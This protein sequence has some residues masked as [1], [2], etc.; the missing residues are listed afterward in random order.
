MNNVKQA[1]NEILQNLPDTP[2]G[3]LLGTVYNQLNDFQ[4]VVLKECCQKESGGLSLPLGS[5][6]TLISL[7]LSLYLTME[8]QELILVVA[9]KS[10]I[11]SWITEIRKFFDED[12]KY[13]VIHPSV[14]KTGVETWK[15]KGCTQLIITTPDILSK[16]YKEN[17]INRQFIEQDYTQQY[18][19]IYINNYQIP[20][21]PYLAHNIGSGLF[22]SIK[23]GCVVID[24][25]QTY[26]N[27][28]TLRCQALGSLCAKY[29]WLLSGT[30]FDEPTVERLLGYHI[31]LNAPGKPRNLPDTKQL[32]YSKATGQQ[33]TFKGLKEHL[34]IRTKNPVFTPPKVYEEIIEH[35][36]L[37]EE[38]KIYTM[39][40]QIL[41]AVKKEARR[42][43]LTNNTDDLKR[44]S[45]YKLVMIMYLRQ[46]LICPLIPIASIAIDASD[47]EK[48]SE[49]SKIIM[50]EIHKLDIDDYLNNVESVKSS[51]IRETLKCLDKHPDE[52]VLVFSC[53]KSYLDIMEYFLPTDRPV[54]RLSA[55]MSLDRRGK[56]IEEFRET[57]NGILLMTYELGATGLNLQFATTVML[58]DFWWNAAKTQQAIGRIFRYGQLANQI[59]IYFF[60]ANTGIENIIFVKQNAKLQVLNELMVGRRI[61][62]VPRI[63]MNQVIQMIEDEDNTELLKKI[64][65]Y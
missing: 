47:M 23:W 22:Y 27:I 17:Y 4:K 49:L 20:Y 36:L 16:Y 24:E 61:T 63:N 64:D 28:K 46:V 14:L 45:S 37:P 38:E 9:S 12:M 35:K 50:G 5:G 42:A 21:K 1:E 30:L 31:M 58:V 26:T 2:N 57:T 53:F 10:L 32:I 25:A 13:E 65:F 41:I 40:K 62:R 8:K 44:F 3:K 34:V 15:P 43:K 51:R 60:T 39:M 59:N 7:L 18:G 55:T 6:K 11:A 54:L 48:K 29:R 19:G 33:N 52:R 56:L